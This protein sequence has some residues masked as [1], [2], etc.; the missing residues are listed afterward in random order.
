MVETEEKPK[1]VKDPPSSTNR[2]NVT[3]KEN[4][5]ITKDSDSKTQSKGVFDSLKKNKKVLFIGIVLITC[6]VGYQLKCKLKKKA[7]KTEVGGSTPST[8]ASE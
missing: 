1:V 5:A 2:N 7:L 8:G 6:I 3:F 4:K